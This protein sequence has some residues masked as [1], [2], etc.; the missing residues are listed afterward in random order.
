MPKYLNSNFGLTLEGLG[1][2]LVIIY[3]LADV[4]SIGGGWISSSFLKRGWTANKA[5]KTAM[6]I[7]ALCVVPIVFVSQASEMWIAVGLL[8]L[9]TAAHQGW[10]ANL[11]TLVS[12]MFP[13]HAV[14]GTWGHRVIPELAPTGEDLVIQKRRFSGFYQT[15][16]EDVLKKHGI[17]E[18]EV[19]GVC[20][21]ICVMDTV[22][23]LANRDYPVSV[24]E[25]GVADFDPEFHAFALRRMAKRY[26]A[27]LV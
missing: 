6:L 4:G 22:G 3:L 18:T 20:T 2:P 14:T 8:G 7:C 11:F 17:S 13:K 27:K 16:L 15:G 12:D 23:G 25:A 10:M 1:L 24:P 21:N 5:R 9:A 19:V 26:G